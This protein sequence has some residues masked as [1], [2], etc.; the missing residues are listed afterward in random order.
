MTLFLKV[1]NKK[2]G[3]T[4]DCFQ[5]GWLGKKI[6]KQMRCRVGHKVLCGQ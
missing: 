5:K 4:K 1:L 6:E 3:V 2:K